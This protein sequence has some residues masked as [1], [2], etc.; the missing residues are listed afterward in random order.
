MEVMPE[1]TPSSEVDSV[2]VPDDQKSGTKTGMG[3]L[4][5]VE[6]LSAARGRSRKCYKKN[7]VSKNICANIIKP[8]KMKVE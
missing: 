5:P 3:K 6:R 8:S 7:E 2:L 4:R 1:C